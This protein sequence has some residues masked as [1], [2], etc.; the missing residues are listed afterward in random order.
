MHGMTERAT[1]AIIVPWGDS[2][3]PSIILWHSRQAFVAAFTQSAQKSKAT[4]TNGFGVTLLDKLEGGGGEQSMKA[5]GSQ[6]PRAVRDSSSIPRRAAWT[7]NRL[8]MY[9]VVKSLVNW[10]SQR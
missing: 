9:T 3:C 6:L 4:F 7:R 2:I 10:G 5:N 8:F 1:E